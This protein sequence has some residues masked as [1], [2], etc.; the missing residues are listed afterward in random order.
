MEKIVKGYSYKSPS[1]KIIKVKPYKR[2][3]KNQHTKIKK[4]KWIWLNFK[5]GKKKI[6][7][8]DWRNK[9]SSGWNRTHRTD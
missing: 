1:G 3:C 6:I 9:F 7:K 2:E 8:W 4:K 5:N